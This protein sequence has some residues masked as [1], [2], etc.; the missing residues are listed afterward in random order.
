MA[1][2]GPTR[3]ERVRP[4]WSIGSAKSGSEA[5]QETATRRHGCKEPRRKSNSNV[6]AKIHSKARRRSWKCGRGRLT[7]G[8]TG[9]RQCRPIHSAVARDD[10]LSH[11]RSPVLGIC[12]CELEL[13]SAVIQSAASQR[14]ES[15]STSEKESA[16]G[17]TKGRGLTPAC[18]RCRRCPWAAWGRGP[19]PAWTASGSTRGRAGP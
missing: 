19:R 13:E 18:Q 8:R 6:E 14:Q 9:L 12:S 11:S 4:S 5:G 2:G 1:G 7:T 15:R 10:A 17:K 3:G 16:G